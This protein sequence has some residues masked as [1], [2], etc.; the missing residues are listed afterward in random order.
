MDSEKT[1][2]E[3]QIKEL[4][5][6]IDQ[7]NGGSSS[8]AYVKNQSDLSASELQDHLFIE[9]M[10]DGALILSKEGLVAQ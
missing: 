7:L 5:N 4:Q 6:R 3:E 1:R 2:L 9:K 8:L 10:S